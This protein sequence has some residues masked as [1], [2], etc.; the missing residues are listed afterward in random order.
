MV[1]FLS[2]DHWKL[3]AGLWGKQSTHQP[4]ILFLPRGR[5]SG[6]AACF[7]LAQPW[8]L[9]AAFLPRVHAYSGDAS[10]LE[11]LFASVSNEIFQQSCE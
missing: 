5:N 1:L 7:A 2:L 8:D 4:C 6:L 11:Y 3:A 10:T 9:V